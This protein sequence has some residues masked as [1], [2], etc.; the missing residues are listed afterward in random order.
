MFRMKCARGKKIMNKSMT[1]NGMWAVAGTM[2][3]LLSVAGAHGQE[4]APPAA[5]PG[6]EGVS[7]AEMPAPQR[8][9]HVLRVEFL[10]GAGPADVRG[11]ISVVVD[12]EMLP[13]EQAK[14]MMD[15]ITR[16][17]GAIF[18]PIGG[19][20]GDRPL[21]ERWRDRRNGDGGQEQVRPMVRGERRDDRGDGGFGDW[22][23]EGGPGRSWFAPDMGLDGEGQPAL[24]QETI[25]NILIVI[26]DVNPTLQTQL[27]ELR[28]SDQSLF[29]QRMRESAR[30]WRELI[31]LRGT[32]PEGYKVA[33]ENAQLTQ[34]RMELMRAWYEAGKAGDEARKEQIKGQL[35]EVLGRQF[36]NRNARS[37][38]EVARLEEQLK[39]LKESLADRASK[40]DA[41]IDKQLDM[42]TNGPRRQPM[43]PREGGTD[44]DKPNEAGPDGD[45]G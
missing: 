39:R 32:D 6:A 1:H 30:Q 44:H 40:R 23:G 9:V 19:P 5:G 35:R 42:L 43:P 29:E 34:R 14:F 2:A 8:E 45:G 41:V 13:P 25:K 3:M 36:D 7:P 37:Q 27:V 15:L 24:D 31:H 10:G 26:G 16:L 38:Q 28:S 17:R 22:T 21:V 4:G 18:A 12:G 33:V 20:G 11:P